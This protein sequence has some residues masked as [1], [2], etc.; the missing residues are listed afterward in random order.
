MTLHRN[1]SHWP[2]RAL[3]WMAAAL[4]LLAAGNVHAQYRVFA[5]DNYENGTLSESLQYKYHAKPDNG[6]VKVGS[7]ADADVPPGILNGIA[8]VECGKNG[9]RF[10]ATPEFRLLGVVNELTLDRRGLG[11]TGRALYQADFYLPA[12]AEKGEN[13]A[14]LAD[15]KGDPAQAFSGWRNYRIGIIDGDKIYF[16]YTD[17]TKK[18]GEP[19]FFKTEPLSGL[20][21][22][23]PGWHR[24]QLIFEGQEKIIC[25]VDGKPTAF[26]PIVDS[27]LDKLQAGIMVTSPVGESRT[28]FADNLSIQWTPDDLPIPD[29]PWVNP[30]QG[31]M[32]TTSAVMPAG[33]PAAAESSAPAASAL[34]AAAPAASAMPGAAAAPPAAATQGT[35][36]WFISADQAWAEAATTGKPVLVLFYAPRARACQ[37][38]EQILQT[39]PTAGQILSQFTPARANTD[40]LSGGDLSQ[41]FGIY[42]VPTFIVMG[43]DGKI[44][45]QKTFDRP[46]AWPEVAAELRAALARA[47]AQP[48]P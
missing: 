37:V 19:V 31:T 22:S 4:L 28:Y 29:S 36:N 6:S 45:G 16:S 42:R 10:D 3:P 35:I 12:K 15:M 25:A 11:D 20:N 17:G 33:Q 8:A 39:D 44:K 9:L 32:I 24:L 48:Q 2:N 18:R 21:V 40:Q 7:Y 46:D 23:R 43:F 38:L 13:L 26:S 14:V 1:Q 47:K 30:M 5:W 27:S 41:R 34:A